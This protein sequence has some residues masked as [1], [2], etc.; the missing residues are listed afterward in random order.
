MLKAAFKNSATHLKDFDM[1]VLGISMG[2]KNHR[3]DAL[4][5]IV[6]LLNTRSHEYVIV[7]VAD[8]LRR[9]SFLA[10]GA[11]PEFAMAQAKKL[12]D[13]WIEENTPIL[14]GL[15]AQWRIA[16]WD[17]FRCDRRFESYK[18]KFEAAYQ[19]SDELREAIERDVTSFYERINGEGYE[20][21]ERERETSTE[22]FI[23]ELAVL[24]I[25]FEDYPAAQLY[26]GRELECFKAIRQGQVEDVPDGLQRARF[27]R[28]NVYDVPANENIPQ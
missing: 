25:Q 20:P 5:A 8:T 15:S 13:E 24:S 11:D 26:P 3:R 2:S 27:F 28:I 14:R 16:R 19:N 4:N 17:E 12:G 6:N 9:F 1:L 18:Q 23:E 10:Q 22:F 7:N 21:N